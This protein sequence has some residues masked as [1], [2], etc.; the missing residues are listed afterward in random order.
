MHDQYKNIENTISNCYTFNLLGSKFWTI[1][2]GI[3]NLILRISVIIVPIVI[4]WYIVYLIIKA[5][6]SEKAIAFKTGTVDL[7]KDIFIYSQISDSFQNLLISIYNALSSI[8]NTLSSLISISFT[9][10]TMLVELPF[11]FIQRCFDKINEYIAQKNH[12][13]RLTL[14]KNRRE[15]QEEWFERKKSCIA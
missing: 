8:I 13:H 7:L 12:E 9:G 3:L 5:F 15:R 10:F 6:S 1:L 4:T 14:E 2:V 11:S